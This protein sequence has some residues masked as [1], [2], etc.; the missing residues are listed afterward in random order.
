MRRKMLVLAMGVVLTAGLLAGC[1]AKEQEADTKDTVAEDGKEEAPGE[2]EKKEPEAG[3]PQEGEAVKSAYGDVTAKEKYKFHVIVKSYSSDFWQATI[4]GA[5]DEAAKLGVDVHCDGPN[6]NSDIADQVQMLTSAI[7]SKPDGIGI[8]ASDQEACLDAMQMAMDAGVP[9]ICFNSGIPAAPEGSVYA[10]AITDNY[11]AGQTAAAHMYEALKDK[12]AGAT[13]PVRIGE[14]NQDATSESVIM[15]GLGFIDK[16]VE[17]CAADGKKTAVTGNDKFVAD[18]KDAGDE[19]SADVII[20][21]RVPSQATS[22]LC[23]T[24]ASVLLN[25]EDLI[26]IMG[27]NQETA[28]GILTAN[29]NLDKLGMDPEQG[30][31][32]GCGFDSGAAIISA[33]EQGIMYGAV[34]QAPRY[35]GQVTVDLLTM[36]ANGE[37]VSDV[38]TPAY[39]YDS[40]NINDPEIA[41]NLIR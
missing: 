19:N 5:E 41:P 29:A 13:A 8:A 28:E 15:R 40:S 30:H 2:P 4:K 23:A 10:T 6:N 35:Q 7:S 33:V 24:E 38:D 31:V 37:K 22:E 11:A 12:I 34:T 18:C 3:E 1:G 25:H 36:V 14:V 17:L 39:W 9:I 26:G 21:V 27:T 20:E 16:M 32:I